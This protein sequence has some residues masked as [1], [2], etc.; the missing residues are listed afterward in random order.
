MMSKKRAI[1]QEFSDNEKPFVSDS[2]GIIE[3]SSN[4][5][6]RSTAQIWLK[7]LF[8]LI[9]LII[10]VGGLT[11]LTD[12]GLSITEWKPITGALPPLSAESWASEFGKYKQIPEYKLQN[13]GMSLNEFKFIYWW[14]WGHR[15]LGRIIGL[16]WFLGFVSLMAFGKVQKSWR[17][18]LLLIGVLIGVQGTVGWWM[19]SSGLTGTVLDVASYRLATHLGLAFIILG[20]ITW[21][22]LLLGRSE[23]YLLQARRNAEPKFT[24]LATGLLYLTFLQILFGALVAGIDAGRSYTD[25]PLMAGQI[26]PPDLFYLSPWWRNFLKIL[27]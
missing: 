17:F 26:F 25:W 16:V 8:L 24:F 2:V 4:D 22:V 3:K 10:L 18:R 6:A 13:E 20:Y 5:I 15:Q 9:V 19:V 7:A 14:E 11:R 21:F 27:V 1:F 12:S 23:S